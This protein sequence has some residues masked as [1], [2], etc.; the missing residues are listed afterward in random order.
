MQIRSGPLRA[1]EEGMII[2]ELAR[3]R[4]FSVAFG[5]RPER[6]HH[7]RMTTHTALA[8][9]EIAAHDLEWRIRLN[10]GN[11]WNIAFDEIHRN[12]LDDAT[13]QDR[14]CCQSGKNHWLGFQP[15]M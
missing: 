8:N 7:L 9:I 6:A 13:D 5:F 12:D 4:V 2:D 15:A 10:S 1:P 3:L 14:D 11:R